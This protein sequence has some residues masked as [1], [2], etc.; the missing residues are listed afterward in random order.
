MGALLTLVVSA[1]FL[2][3]SYKLKKAFYFFIFLIP[4][5]P[6]YIGFSIGMPITL[7]RIILMIFFMAVTISFIQNKEYITKWL[8]QVYQQN[9]VLINTLLIFS[10]LKFISL[11][12]GSMELKQYIMLYNDFLL[13]G[14][15]F[16]LITIL[17][18]SEED[19][20][21]IAKMLFYGYVI[22]L[23]LV[24]IESFV[25]HPLFTIFMSGEMSSKD[26]SQGVF[27]G[28][29]YRA[30]GSFN[31][32]ITLGEYLIILFP[33]VT[34]YIYRQKYSFM[35]K[36]FFF[37]LFLYAVYATGTRG[38]MLIFSILVYIYILMILYN[39]GTPLTRFLANMLNILIMGIIFYFAYF[40][41]FDLINNFQGRF[42]L[43]ADQETR[44]STSR[45]LQ[46]VEV[47][48]KIQEAP[49][50]GFGRV[51]NFSIMLGFLIDNRYF[52]MLLEVGIIG[53]LVYFFFL[54]TLAKTAF[55]LYK[56]LYRSYYVFPILL[57]ILA[58]IPYK[59]LTVGSENLIYIYI[60]AGLISVLKVLQNEKD[61]IYKKDL[62]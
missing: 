6:K 13:T 10:A 55:S 52:W 54:F 30:Q 25:Q 3:V 8:S 46:F 51:P 32:A 56:S 7:K 39:R 5:L 36:A 1:Y 22:V 24:L 18:T 9:K 31:T 45:A 43:I 29:G 42:D 62:V 17:V 20:D 34:A 14:F 26:Y 16:I 61:K 23:I 59:F 33:I 19:I 58:Y 4:F 35:F 11:S 27:R 40:Y 50:F 15:V 28:D 49:F 57:G 12:L 38:A 37:V 21:R 48:K 47:Y 60:F 44:S 2:V 53:I 41:V